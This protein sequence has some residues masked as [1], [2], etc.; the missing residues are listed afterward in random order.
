MPLRSRRADPPHRTPSRHPP[1]ASARGSDA[2]PSPRTG[3]RPPSQGARTME[4]RASTLR[5]PTPP[6][7]PPAV[8]RF[9]RGA[10]HRRASPEPARTRRPGRRTSTPTP[11]AY[12]D[13]Q[14]Q[15]GRRRAARRAASW[16]ASAAGWRSTSGSWNSPRTRRPRCWNGPTSWRSSPA[17]STSSSWSASPAS[18]AGSPP[19]SP[20]ARASGLQPREVLDLIWNRSRE[21][22][23]RHAACFQHDVAPALADEGIAPHPLARADREGAGPAVHALPAADLPGAHP[24][25]RRPR[26]PVP[27][28][29]RAVAQPRGGRAQPGQRAPALRAGEGAAAAVALPGGRRRSATSRWRTSSRRT[30]R[31]C[32]P[33]WRC[34][35]TTCSG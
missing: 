4:A 26:A 7:R 24:A 3:A 33:A 22:M 23:A 8:A 2:R 27:V 1:P 34:S 29:L 5:A 20:P 35:R 11:T 13:G 14:R 9:A 6:R 16:T 19:A 12:E 30:W 25:G 10:P 31:S 21:L 32:S 28:H 15:R 18:S 17:T